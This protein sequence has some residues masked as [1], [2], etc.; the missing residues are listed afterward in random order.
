[1]TDNRHIYDD[2][3]DY[4]NAVCPLIEF[5]LSLFLRM[6]PWYLSLC[7]QLYKKIEPH[8]TNKSL[9]LSLGGRAVSYSHRGTIVENT[10][11][12]SM[13]YGSRSSSMDSSSAGAS[14]DRQ[15]SSA[16][17]E[18]GRGEDEDEEDE[19]DEEDT[20]EQVIL[21]SNYNLSIVT[22]SS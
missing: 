12:K 15:E 11:R 17:S 16:T 6:S 19:E 13:A 14:F 4:R 8:V 5:A 21:I 9:F 3:L 1:M 18:G 22:P 7:R 2:C 10:S 20:E